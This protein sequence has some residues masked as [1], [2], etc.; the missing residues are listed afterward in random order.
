MTRSDEQGNGWPLGGTRWR[1]WRSA[2]L[3][4]AG[5][6]AAGVT[7]F[8]APTLTAAAD[9]VLAGRGTETGA[10]KQAS[11][12]QWSH[13]RSAYAEAT[14]QLGREVVALAGDP[15]FREAVTWQ[16]PTAL[17][18]MLDPVLAKGTDAPRNASRRGKEAGIVR[19]YS[20]Y[21]TKNDTIGFFGPVCWATLDGSEVAMGMKAGPDLLRRREVFLERWALVAYA[22]VLAADPQLRAW[23]PAV[24]SPILYVDGSHL[25][26]PMQGR[27]ELSPGE[28]AILARCDARTPAR[29]FAYDLAQDPGSGIRR[30]EDVLL[31]LARLAEAEIVVWGIDLPLTVR[32]EEVLVA[33]VD[34]IGDA[35][36][37]DR[38]GSGL[39][40]LRA[41][42]DMV[43]DAAGDH[44]ALAEAM[45][46]LDDVF[47]EISGQAATQADG[48]TY[49]GRTVCYEET[50]RDLD[51][52]I[53]TP[54][55]DAVADPL[56]L[57]L[58]SARWL[59]A[60][61]A[62]VY[63]RALRELFDELVQ[64]RSDG[65]VPLGELWFLAQGM[66]YGPGAKPIDDVSA[67]FTRRWSGLLGLDSSATRMQWTSA[68]LRAG[69]EQQFPHR[70]PGWSAARYHSPDIHLVF[71]D[72][73]LSVD[74]FWCVLGELHA[75]WNT[76]DSACFVFGHDDPEQLQAWVDQDLP[77]GRV[78]PLLPTSWPRLTPRTNNA[79]AN[80]ADPQLG[81]VPA[82]GVDPDRIVPVTAM[83]VSDVDG[84][85]V[86]AT[87]DGRRW[88]IVEVFAELLAT[89]AVDAF[90]LLGS[91]EHSPRVTIDRMVVAR[92]SWC[93][94][95]GSLDFVSVKDP[96]ERF[97]AV[98]AWQAREGLPERV[99]VKSATEV[100]PIYVDLSSPA[101]VEILGVTVRAAV[102]GGGEAAKVVVSEMLPT[103]EQAWVRDAEG[104]RYVSELRLQIVD[105]D[106]SG[107]NGPGESA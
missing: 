60:E 20:R 48:Q 81:F 76:A 24:L 64:E 68:Q 95:V 74:G 98:R 88:P 44:T 2:L 43:A 5:F 32:A 77:A 99:F 69:V 75:A 58:D 6:D 86:A 21:T 106:T 42:R 90:K 97:L 46:S 78:I 49:A 87:P 63:L 79:L 82:P 10:H 17:T 29:S 39:D 57:L 94:A 37:R 31:T 59:S 71:A 28:R 61:I 38:A 26:H 25:V 73:E 52:T 53:G 56:E 16:N 54:L 102:R 65:I 27:R 19:Y 9:D 23:L 92:E 1:V 67:D 7:R 83:T 8:S 30:A 40:Q 89:H 22:D 14:A 47:V 85:L 93:Y 107:W 34:R 103:P 70:L 101:H 80:P 4:G 104:R 62:S 3:R 51:V 15:L 91:F 72:D 33:A 13:Y 105:S 35:A 84:Q 11:D 12:A 18:T 36:L 96:A 66:F 45:T 55:L 50:V 41:A 100:K